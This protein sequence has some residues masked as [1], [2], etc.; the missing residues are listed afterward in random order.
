M[1]E[2]E[3]QNA[4]P[5]LTLKYS[6]ESSD[7]FALQ[8]IETALITAKP[9]FAND[10]MFS[11]D[12]G[13]DYGIA[14]CYNGLLIGGGSFTLVRLNLA[15]LSA[16]AVDINDYLNVQLP[17]AVEVMSEYIDERIS[18]LVEEADFFNSSFLVEEGLID[19]SKFTAMFGIVGLAEAVNSLLSV[20]QQQDRFGYGAEANSLGLRIITE[21][22]KLVNQHYNQY[23]QGSKGR[24]LLHAQVGT[25]FDNNISPG[26]RIP[27]GEEPPILEHL[28]QSSVFHKFFP[29]GIGDIFKFDH[30][31]K[32]NPAYLLDIIKGSFKEGIRYISFYSGDCD[33]IRI[34]GYLVK[35]SEMNKLQSGKQV[36]HDSV[37]LGLGS[38]N[39][40]RILERRLRN[41][42]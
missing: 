39:N 22:N 41:G 21:L 20:E 6:S 9:S 5:N 24:F 13:K 25:D 19:S 30:T 35:R 36:L 32:N 3:L 40:Q 26:C 23:C 11:Q 12:L 28:L 8:A 10:D 4:V 34:T 33:V 42:E 1:A 14:S 27:I 7:E 17:K 37:V 29:S 18:F 2:A 31:V 16:E 15:V 38:A